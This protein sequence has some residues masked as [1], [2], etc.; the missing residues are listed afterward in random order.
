MNWLS[1][2]A[3]VVGLV[4]SLIEFLR[5]RGRIDAATTEVLLRSNREALDAITQAN[6]ARAGVRADVER[7]PA[8]VMSDDGFKRND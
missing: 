7:D 8:G 6:A 3:A 2:I 4:R 5:D 1:A